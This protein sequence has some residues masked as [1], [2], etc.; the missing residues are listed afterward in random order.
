MGRGT[1]II[2]ISNVYAED[3]FLELSGVVRENYKQVENQ[4]LWLVLSTTL[5]AIGWVV[6][7]YS[8][9]KNKMNLQKHELGR[10]TLC[11]SSK[12]GAAKIENRS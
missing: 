5:Q 11:G 2:T 8:Y 3:P 4:F 9:Y 10:M 6:F 1:C 12:G 7:A